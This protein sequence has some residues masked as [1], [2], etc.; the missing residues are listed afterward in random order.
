MAFRMGISLSDF[1]RMTPYEF[2][3]YIE[4]Y[5]EVEEERSKQLIAQAY[6]TEVFARMKKL[7]KLEKILNSTKPKKKQTDEEMLEVVKKLNSMFGGEIN[8]SS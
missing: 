2:F 7:P 4:S 6:Y 8:G 5:A 3:L 1:W